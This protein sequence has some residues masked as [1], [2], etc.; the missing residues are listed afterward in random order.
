MSAEGLPPASGLLDSPELQE[1]VDLQVR[2]DGAALTR[3][4]DAPEASIRARAAL[5]L[6][7]VQDQRAL[8]PLSA[9]LTDP[10]PIVRRHAAFALGQLALP[11]GGGFLVDALRGEAD[12]GVRRSLLEAI[13]KRAGIA[14]V[15]ALL[16]S[17]PR[18]A[19]E[20]TWTMALANAALRDVRPAGVLEALIDRLAHEDP[21]VRVRAAYYFGRTPNV[22]AWRDHAPRVRAWLDVA[23]TDDRAAMHLVSGLGRLAEIEEDGARLASWMRSAED[24]RVRVNAVTA[25]RTPRWLES[26]GIQDAVVLSLDDPSPHVRTAA[27]EALALLMWSSE[28]LFAR[29]I[30]WLRGPSE[31]WRVQLAFLAP[32]ASQGE[33]P[34]VLDWI[35]RM[36]EI[37]PLAAAGGI[38]AVGGFR[39]ATVTELLF[40]LV[41]HPDALVRSTVVSALA[42]RLSS[43]A[44]EEEL[45]RYYEVFVRVVLEDAAMPAVRAAMALSHPALQ[46]LGA[47]DVLEDAFQVHRAEGNADVLIP[48]LDGL[49]PDAI[50]LLREVVESDDLRLR[51]AAA[52]TLQELT[53]RRVPTAGD[54]PDE[55]TIDWETLREIGS[56]PRVRIETD[57]GAIIVRLLTDQAPLTVQTF[58]SNVRSG[59]YDGTRFHR[60]VPNFVAQGGDFSMGDGTGSPGSR[61]RSEFTQLSFERGVLGMASSGKDTEGSQFY[62]THSLQPHLDGGYTAF[63]WLAEGGEALDLI[64]QGDRVIRMELEDG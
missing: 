45:E 24:W 51:Q 29:G 8:E 47:P 5:A 14:A 41:D 54:G 39:P 61:I 23:P 55:P 64:Q 4:L 19:D 40:E 22:N 49:G 48:I 28:E 16:A 37:R 3:L 44:P 7:S 42:G 60:V 26:E 25:V 53:G 13:G 52:R 62:L 9:R 35:R 15:E 43:Q 18:E 31:Q 1:V 56:E 2:R 36:A 27:A 32:L 38:E 63:G 6:A 57:H 10:D 34:L 59:A 46:S 50:L 17:E 12:G 20:P 30:E 33:L 11:E 21:E 58:V